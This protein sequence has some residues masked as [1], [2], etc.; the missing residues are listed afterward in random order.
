MPEGMKTIVHTSAV[1]E[2]IPWLMGET[3]FFF[4]LYD[5]PDLVEALWNRV[6]EIMLAV[7]RQASEIPGVGAIFFGDDLG[8][9][10]AT[11][12]KPEL[13]RRFVFPWHRRI[14][15]AVHERG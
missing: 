14:V 8:Y 13:L 11:M 9:K 2:M 5:Q 12:I 3:A 1:Y 7:C 15:E 10:T 4:A 6:G